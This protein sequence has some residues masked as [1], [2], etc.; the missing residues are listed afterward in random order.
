[1]SLD[2]TETQLEYKPRVVERFPESQARL[3]AWVACMPVRDAFVQ[4]RYEVDVWYAPL[5]NCSES[6]RL[7]PMRGVM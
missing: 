7:Q 1:M 4:P 3:P 2:S 6:D 5:R